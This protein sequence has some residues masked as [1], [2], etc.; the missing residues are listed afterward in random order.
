MNLHDN[1]GPLHG[2]DLSQL[3]Q[4]DPAAWVQQTLLEQAGIPLGS[5]GTV[6]TPSGSV[7]IEGIVILVMF[8]PPA[9]HILGVSGTDA[10]T[11]GKVAIPWHAVQ[12]MSATPE[13]E[14]HG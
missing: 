7:R 2:L 8:V 14:L 13:L 5:R 4:P 11:G 9:L 10:A 6:V 3:K 12:A 1:G